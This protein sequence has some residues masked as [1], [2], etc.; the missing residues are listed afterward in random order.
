MTKPVIGTGFPKIH[1]GKFQRLDA[2]KK[3]TDGI[4]NGI[5]IIPCVSG[6]N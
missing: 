2:L 5:G 1:V 6:N 4:P 3:V